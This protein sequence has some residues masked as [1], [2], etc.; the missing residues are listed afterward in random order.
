MAIIEKPLNVFT[1]A[2]LLGYYEYAPHPVTGQTVRKVDVGRLCTHP[3]INMW[4]KYKPVDFN[5]L[6]E[7]LP[8]DFATVNFGLTPP[9]P[10]TNY[11]TA[12]NQ[13]W[14]Y[15]RP[16]GGATSPFRVADFNNYNHSAGAIV[17]VMGDID[18]YKSST[19]SR[20]IHLLMNISGSDFQ[21][22]LNDFIGEIG[23]YYYGVVFESGLNYQYK[24]IKTAKLN[25]GYDTINNTP[26]F[27]SSKNSFDISM[28]EPPFR[29][30]QSQPIKLYHVLVNQA[31][32]TM[33]SLGNVTRSFLSLPSDRNNISY[34]TIKEAGI[35]GGLQMD[36]VSVEVNPVGVGYPIG[37]YRNI[38]GDAFYTTGALYIGFNLRNTSDTDTA[39]FESGSYEMLLNRTYWGDNTTRIAVEAYNEQGEIAGRIRVPPNSTR[40]VWVGGANVANNHNGQ[41]MQVTEPTKV[42]TDIT[43]YKNSAR[44]GSAALMLKSNINL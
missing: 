5:K 19:S 17:G 25:I 10:T 1:I 4:S 35:A 11:V 28:I 20:N 3:S 43:I 2:D 22:G 39:S 23:S 14:G 8:N 32:P 42:F 7:L 16:Q 44:V 34:I 21:I 15:R 26:P 29:E 40:F 37:D 31:V 9:T 27:G 33:Q 38:D 12:A 6:T 13:K 24:H 41:V 18:L 36:A 30:S